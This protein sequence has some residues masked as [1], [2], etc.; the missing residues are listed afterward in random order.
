MGV[1]FIARKAGV[2]IAKEIYSGD[3]DR[4]FSAIEKRKILFPGSTF[5]T[6]K[7]SDDT[8]QDAFN[9]YMP[10][11]KTKAQEDWDKIKAGASVRETFLAKKL[12]LE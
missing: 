10:K 2:I 1:V 11:I 5:E 12:G 3:N 8:F 4:A 6:H 9:L 7:D